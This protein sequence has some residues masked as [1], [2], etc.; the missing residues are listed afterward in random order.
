ML[1]AFMSRVNTLPQT[2]GSIVNLDIHTKVCKLPL[3]HILYL[4]TKPFL[5]WISCTCPLLSLYGT[6]DHCLLPHGRKSAIFQFNVLTPS[7]VSQTYNEYFLSQCSILR[8]AWQIDAWH[9][10]NLS[11]NYWKYLVP[12][13]S[14]I[15]RNTI[16]VVCPFW[17][18]ITFNPI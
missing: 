15:Y 9:L 11:N 3:R 16:P 14:R 5:F 10:T 13:M 6:D 2:F 4:Q 12:F 7:F 17:I 8:P 1:L 18:W